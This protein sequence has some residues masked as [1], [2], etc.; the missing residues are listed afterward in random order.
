M[1]RALMKQARLISSLALAVVVS[2]ATGCGWMPKVKVPFTGGSSA[3]EDPKVPFDVKRPLAYG[4]TLKLSV[5]R[6]LLSRSRLFEGSVMVDQN[7]MVHF[8]NAGDVH[9]GGR[10]AFDAVKAIEAAFS[11]QYGDSTVS[12]QLFSIEDV[13]LVTITGAVRKPAVIQWFDNMSAEAALPYV[14]GRTSHGD[15]HA[16]HVT[17][18]G[19]RHFHSQSGGVE[20]KAGDVVNFSRDI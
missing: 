10:T 11:R 17:R 4:H 18:D 20:L 12:V 6:N 8:K 16:V 1:L 7:G 3:A 2:V 13:P 19:V 5:Y 9:A 14:G 15:A